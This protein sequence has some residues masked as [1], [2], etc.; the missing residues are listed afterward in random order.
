MLG[1][2]DRLLELADGRVTASEILA[3]ADREPVRRR[4]R[5]DDDDVDPRRGVGSRRWG[6]DASHRQPFNL[7]RFH[8]GT[9]Q[10]GLDR[11]LV[12][13]TTTEADSRLVGGVLPL[14]DVG[15]PSG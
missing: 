15:S 9:W 10:A 1:V 6:L 14:D 4:F 3:L 13:V 11:V 8:G 12:G 5:L 2:V 7:D